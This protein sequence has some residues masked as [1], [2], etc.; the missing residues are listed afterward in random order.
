MEKQRLENENQ[1]NKIDLQATQEELKQKE[2]KLKN[3]AEQLKNEKLK[4]EKLEHDKLKIQVI[5]NEMGSLIRKFK[6]VTPILIAIIIATTWKVKSGYEIELK[7]CEHENHKY[8]KDLQEKQKELQA[9]NERY[10]RLE[11][12]NRRI[13]SEN[14]EYKD[15]LKVEQEKLQSCEHVNQKYQNDLQKKDKA[16]EEQYKT[17]IKRESLVY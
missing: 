4:N 7:S 9:L 8:E 6:F 11:I 17:F 10:N 2:M 16:I 13:E 5:K 12:E 14:Q 3:E 15:A 1:K